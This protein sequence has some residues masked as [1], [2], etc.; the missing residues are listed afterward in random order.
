MLTTD[1]SCSTS[2]SIRFERISTSSSQC[3]T[4]SQEIIQM[5]L[6]VIHIKLFIIFKRLLVSISP[7]CFLL[8]CKVLFIIEVFNWLVSFSILKVRLRYLINGLI[9]NR[10][11]IADFFSAIKMIFVF[12][13]VILLI[14][15]LFHC[16]N[17]FF[18]A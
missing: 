7:L 3:S 11:M 17:F 9:L 14:V 10:I 16:C 4:T 18:R 13:I 6:A 1:N 12:R 5:R 8:L 2:T 15:M